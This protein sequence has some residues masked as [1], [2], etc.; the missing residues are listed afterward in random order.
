MT[1]CL[2]FEY[3]HIPPF[4]G[5]RSWAIVRICRTGSKYDYLP[6]VAPGHLADCSHARSTHYMFG[7]LPEGQDKALSKVYQMSPRTSPPSSVERIQLE[8]ITVFRSP[9]NCV[10]PLSRKA[11]MKGRCACFGRFGLIRYRLGQKV[12]CS[13]RCREK[14]RSDAERKV[15]RKGLDGIS[16]P[17]GLRG[18]PDIRQVTPTLHPFSPDH[19]GFLKC[20]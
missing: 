2:T 8:R 14:Y 15:S 18:S 4:V 6:F 9:R 11:S 16:W 5:A 19:S 17:K 20:R 10:A 3:L 7:S 1:T 13:K 12:F